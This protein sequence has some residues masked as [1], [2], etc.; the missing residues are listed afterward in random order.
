[1]TI[2]T[3]VNKAQEVLNQCAEFIISR[4]SSSAPFNI[5]VKNECTAVIIYMIHSIMSMK[6]SQDSALNYEAVIQKI[7][8]LG[9]NSTFLK[10]V[11]M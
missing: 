5:K 1:M 2:N 3:I 4:E 11:C 8:E 7:S 10:S 6:N 9:V